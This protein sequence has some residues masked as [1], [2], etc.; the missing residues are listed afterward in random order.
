MP[1]FFIHS[2]ATCEQSICSMATSN[3]NYFLFIVHFGL[4]VTVLDLFKMCLVEE[5][6]IRFTCRYHYEFESLGNIYKLIVKKKGI[7][8][9][10]SRDLVEREMK[11]IFEDSA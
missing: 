8:G 7:L 4:R 6:L 5:P 1:V 11:C 2:T 3:I 10:Q 9:G